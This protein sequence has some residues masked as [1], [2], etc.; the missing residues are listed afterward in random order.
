MADMVTLDGNDK[1]HTFGNPVLFGEFGTSVFAGKFIDFEVAM[2][3]YTG[4]DGPPKDPKNPPDDYID[5][6]DTRRFEYIWEVV[7]QYNAPSDVIDTLSDDDK[8]KYENKLVPVGEEKT[9]TTHLT[10]IE[11]E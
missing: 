6:P 1:N 7:P 11:S 10:T 8:L 4:P 9:S 5:D 2:P 3:G